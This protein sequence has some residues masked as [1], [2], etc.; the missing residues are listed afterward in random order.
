M[1]GALKVRRFRWP[2]HS[3]DLRAKVTRP[4]LVAL[5]AS[6]VL[7]TGPPAQALPGDL[8][9]TFGVD[10]IVTTDFSPFSIDGGRA[11]ALESLGLFREADNGTGMGIA[12]TDLA[13]LAT[14]E[15]RHRDAIRLAAASESLKER[16]GGPPGGFAGILDGDPVAEARVHLSDEEA[17]RAWKEGLAMSVDEAT[18]LARTET[19]SG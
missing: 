5:V 16:I 2:A 19:R 6:A 3:R 11:I 15:G 7:T 4:V 14:W 8:D 1:P 17:D 13:F 10:G 9:P 12:F 18:A